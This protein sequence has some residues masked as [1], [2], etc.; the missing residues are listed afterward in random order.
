MSE[1]ELPKREDILVGQSVV[2]EE[3]PSLKLYGWLLAFAAFLL[4]LAFVMAAPDWP[5]FF[6][7]LAT[8]IVGAVIIL[9]LVE[10]KLRSHEVEHLKITASN[11]QA[12]IYFFFFPGLRKLAQY[13][14][15][16]SRNYDR[17]DA[18][19]YVERPALE[20]EIRNEKQSFIL[21]GPPGSGK[22]TELQRH[23]LTICRETIGNLSRGKIPIF[24][25]ARWITPRIKF[26]EDTLR[27]HFDNDSEIAEKQINKYL[28]EGRVVLLV[29]ALDEVSPKEREEVV[30][31][32]SN[33]SNTYPETQLI[34]SS[35]NKCP[36][37]G[38]LNLKAVKKIIEIPDLSIEE[39]KR[40]LQKYE[41]F[42]QKT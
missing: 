36:E 18:E 41:L 8:E 6:L 32:L 15:T 40:F 39:R 1:T 21:L 42:R 19:L 14:E 5:G 29:D 31:I 4:L 9:A 3:P 35:R 24:I 7:N 33:F 10:R 37:T 27:L 13:L 34:V 28:K 11:L 16:T 20:Q 26:V 30:E 23:S 17:L 25:P 12:Q 22:T 38:L 2:R